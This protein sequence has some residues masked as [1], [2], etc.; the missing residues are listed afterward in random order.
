MKTRAFFIAVLGLMMS[1]AWDANA[2]QQP[3]QPPLPNYDQRKQ[4]PTVAAAS[5]SAQ[6]DAAI[7]LQA[8]VPTVRV[9]RH[10]VL[11][12]PRV[13]SA[14]RGFLTG[15]GGRGKGLNP[16]SLE[17]VPASDPHRVVKAFVNEHSALFGHDARAFDSARVKTDYVTP[18]NGLRT[19]IWQQ[20]L[21][22]VPVYGG[23][24]V[25]HLTKN[26]E[27]AAISD[28]FVPDLATAS[29][30]LPDR[31]NL[32][33]TPPLTAQEALRRAA[34]NLG[35]TINTSDVE[36]SGDGPLGA[37]KRQDYAS[38]ELRGPAHTQLVWLP[39]SRSDLK[40]CW[41]VILTARSRPEMYLVLVDAETG[42]VLLRHC[43]TSHISDATYNVFP[44]DSPSP[45]SPGWP[46][47]DPSQ[48][49]LTNRTLITLSALNTNA[50]PNGWIND[51]G[52]ET[53]GNNVDAHLDRNDNNAPDLPRPQGNPNRVFD[54]PLD[55]DLA[56]LSY[57]N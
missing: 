29:S 4:Q 45:F 32:V 14:Q 37:E 56:P 35:Q 20:T 13:L 23:L 10:G 55:L 12:T 47:P 54:F 7:A 3:E 8:R 46:T 25:S 53:R 19:V 27:L 18:H 41:Q 52:N 5:S 44:S 15:V 50:S 21:D 17:S 57:G 2:I 30:A 51:G 22:D 9:V 1:Q 36:V 39:L 42:E 48:P 11:G 26:A 49:P 40:L 31:S 38:S 28:R 34:Q 6:D 16:A 43:L 24:F 33:S